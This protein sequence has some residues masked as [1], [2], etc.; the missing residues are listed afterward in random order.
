[1]KF[2]ESLAGRYWKD[3][4]LLVEMEGEFVGELKR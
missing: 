2:G 3:A 1:M 4:N